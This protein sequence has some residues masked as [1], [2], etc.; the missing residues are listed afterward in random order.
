[1]PII[2]PKD[3]L[4]ETDKSFPIP[5][6]RFEDRSISNNNKYV[7]YIDCFWMAVWNIKTRE[8]LWKLDSMDYRSENNY[9]V[10]I[11][12]NNKYVVSAGDNI[13]LRNIQ[14]GEII[15][16]NEHPHGTAAALKLSGDGKDIVSACTCIC[17]FDLASGKLKNKIFMS[18]DG[19][20]YTVDFSNVAISR[21]NLYIAANL[22]LGGTVV[23]NRSGDIVYVLREY[24]F[25]LDASYIGIE[26][27]F[28]LDD[29]YL[30][31]L[32]PDQ[33]SIDIWEMETGSL[34]NTLNYDS[35][36]WGIKFIPN[37]SFLMVKINNGNIIIWNY[38]EEESNEF[39]YSKEMN[40]I[41]Q[42]ELFSEA[43]KFKKDKIIIQIKDFIDKQIRHFYKNPSKK[44]IRKLD[45]MIPETVKGWPEKYIPFVI[46]EYKR[47]INFYGELQ[48]SKWKK[49]SKSLL[50]LIP[51]IRL[52]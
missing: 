30:A 27:E 24:D 1:M 39:K 6:Q 50:N 15:W 45:K 29:N 32:R 44:L 8:C 19:E 26:L 7:A 5:D 37:K 47:A 18:E 23:W 28:S 2:I 4:P 51:Y 20:E 40:L 46:E 31:S 35:E 17:I 52:E 3:L 41:S 25:D 22:G 33:K 10:E 36:M 16:S 21:N 43:M 13:T 48:P 9:C 12:P 34:I 38:L 42:I 11:T 14:S 49:W